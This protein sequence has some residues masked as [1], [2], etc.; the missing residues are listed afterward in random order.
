MEFKNFCPVL[1]SLVWVGAG[2]FT[3]F[4]YIT[5]MVSM[6]QIWVAVEVPVHDVVVEGPFSLCSVRLL[7]G[8]QFAALFDPVEAVV[9]RGGGG[10]HVFG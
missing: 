3:F 1:C 8:V 10:D 2:L 5:R 7:A 6:E 4:F 9:Y